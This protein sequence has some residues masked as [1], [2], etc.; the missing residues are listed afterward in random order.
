M[1][2]GGETLSE[3]QRGLNL[4][5]GAAG[6]FVGAHTHCQHHLRDSGEICSRKQTDEQH[7]QRRSQ[8]T[9]PLADTKIW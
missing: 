2:R 9:I 4:G 7:K 5:G 1:L 3:K 8:N 6:K